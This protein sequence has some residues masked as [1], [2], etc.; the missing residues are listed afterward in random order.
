MLLLLLVVIFLLIK[1]RK[2]RDTAKSYKPPTTAAAGAAAAAAAAGEVG[3]S[4]SKDDI[5]ASGEGAER[6]KL[7]FFQ[8]GVYTFDL[9]DLLR[10]SAE[11]LGKGSVGT[12]YKA[13][14]EEGT[15]VV[16]K[17]LKDVAAAKKE[18]EQ[19]MEILGHIKHQNVL[20]L[21]AYYFSKDEKLLVYDYMPAGSLSA[22]LHGKCFLLL[23]IFYHHHQFFIYGFLVTIFNFMCSKSN[24]IRT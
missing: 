12:S 13:V 24:H 5:T 22:L 17:R 19:Q 2:T 16:V 7:V 21:R 14:L 15:T 23:F 1:K 6:N 10:A 18:F 3:T 20:P 4:S 9:E 8:G 11:V